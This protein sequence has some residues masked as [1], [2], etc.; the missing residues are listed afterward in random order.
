M[1]HRIKPPDSNKLRGSATRFDRWA[2]SLLLK[3]LGQIE[4]CRIA[5]DETHAVTLEQAMPGVVRRAVLRIN[6]PRCFSHI[7]LAGTTGA[8]ESYILGYWDCDDLQTLIEIV[9]S[10]PAAYTS[11]DSGWA[12]LAEKIEAVLSRFNR[13]S[14]AGSLKNIMAHY[15]LGND[16]FSIFLDATM[17]YSCGFFERPDSSLREASVAKFDRI[18]RK[19][20]L[21]SADS[22]IEIGTGWGG[23][24]VHAAKH[25]GCRVTTT[26]ISREQYLKARERVQAEGVEELVTVIDKD[27]RDLT[28]SYSRLVSIEMIEAVGHDYLETFFGICGRLLRDDGMMLIQG[29]TVPDDRYETHRQVGSFINKYI[30]PGSHLVSV[31]SVCAAVTAATDMFLANVEDI[32]PHYVRTLH[33][34]RDGFLANLDKVRALGMSEPF[35]RMWLFYLIFCEAGFARRWTGDVQWVFGKPGCHPP[36][37]RLEPCA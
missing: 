21:S 37:M 17:A 14:P 18:C 36:V 32:T 33:A 20:A 5:A 35:I 1:Q 31:R 6:D 10:S 16:F 22:L 8:A 34:W 4:N 26:T 24:A 9:L 13:N 15:D 2:R 29:I 11:I 30:F 23:F 12:W 27:Y 19:L 3:K 25:Y 7:L 28:G